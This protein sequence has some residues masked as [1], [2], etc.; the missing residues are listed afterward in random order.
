MRPRRLR[1]ARPGPAA[2]AAPPRPPARPRSASSAASGRATRTKSWPAGTVDGGGPERLAQQPLH[3]VALDRAAD[4]AADRDAEARVVGVA[5]AREGVEHEV[6]AGVRAALA[7]DPLELGAAGEPAPPSLAGPAALGARAVGHPQ[8][9]SRLRP[10]RRRRSRIARPPRVRMRARNPCV[11][12]RLRFLGWYV[13]FT[14]EGAEGSASRMWTSCE[15]PFLAICGESKNGLR[16]PVVTRCRLGL[17]EGLTGRRGGLRDLHDDES[18]ATPPEAVRKP[19]PDELETIWDAVRRE[20]RRDVTDFSFH[21][22]LEP[23]EPVACERRDAVRPRAGAHPQLGRAT[24]T[25]RSSRGACRRAASP[26][27]SSSTRP[28]P[29]RRARRLPLPPMRAEGDGLNP[30]YTFEQFV[31][32]DGNRLAHAAAL[33]VAELPAQ[34]WN[35]LF[36]HGPPGLGKTHLLHAIGNYVAPLRRGPAGPLRHRRGRSRPSSS[37]RSAAA[38]RRLPG[39]LP[40]RG[41]PAARRRPVPR[42]QGAHQGGALP[43]LQ[44]AVRVGP[45]ARHHERPQPGGPRGVRGAAQGALRVRPRGRA[46][47]RRQPASAT[48]SSASA[49]ARTGS[50]TSPTRRSRPWRGSSAPACGCSRAR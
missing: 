40:R 7:I 42:R 15:H 14:G 2:R 6:P 10:L 13:R 45:P 22:W 1:A 48:R 32:G 34:A 29:G 19:V 30:K 50:R 5:R 39:A 18:E 37:R 33:A 35:P 41:R 46:R 23:L 36:I 21:I 49:S 17:S 24:A 3:P 47:R 20:L 31:I 26:P 8:G 28:G 4:L 9:V 11:R 27:S 44:R 12:A 25:R 43:H 38:H 16:R